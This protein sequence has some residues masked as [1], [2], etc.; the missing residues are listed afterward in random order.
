MKTI[1]KVSLH[2]GYHNYGEQL[3][4]TEESADVYYTHLKNTE[5][6]HVCK[7]EVTLFETVDATQGAIDSDLI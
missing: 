5:H 2:D 1:F 4:S 3:F 7:E 6:M